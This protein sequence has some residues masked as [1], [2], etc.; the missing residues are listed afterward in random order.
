M[1][2]TK[3][4]LGELIMTVAI[5]AGSKIYQLYKKKSAEETANGPIP[6]TQSGAATAS[7]Q[8][9]EEVKGPQQQYEIDPNV[10][11]ESI[12]CPI[13]MVVIQEP[14]TTIYGHLFELSAI[15][16][17]VSMRGECPLTNQPL[18]QEQ[19]YPQY[20]LKDTIDEMRRMREQNEAGQRRIRELEA[21][22]SS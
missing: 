17:W 20:G 10:D 16:E 22:V 4:I 14:A 6:Q 9:V 18:S 3:T 15:R 11:I 12:T 2:K 21:M 1:S 8:D 7:E 5:V 13:T 19:I